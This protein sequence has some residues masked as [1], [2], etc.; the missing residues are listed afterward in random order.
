[1]KKNIAR[2]DVNQARKAAVDYCRAAGLSVNKF[3]SDRR[4]CGNEKCYFLRF[5]K[6]DTHGQGLYADIETQ[7]VP[8]LIVNEDYSVEETEHTKEYL[9]P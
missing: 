8:I 7:G 3:L 4:C 1:M 6:K 5:P 9:L 2:I